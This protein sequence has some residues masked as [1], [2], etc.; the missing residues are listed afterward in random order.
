MT[1]NLPLARADTVRDGRGMQLATMLLLPAHLLRR[2]HQL[3]TAIFAEELQKED[4]T[5]IQYATMVAVA[6]LGKTDSTTIS[7]RIGIDRAT[8]GGVVDR[9]ERKGLLSRTPSSTD[10]RVKMLS[11]T[12]DGHAL[13]EAIEPAVMNVQKLL[14]RNLT[15]EESEQFRELLFK[16]VKGTDQSTEQPD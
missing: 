14:T 2:A 5:A 13:L 7:R 3:S 11:V 1:D 9:L 10:R 16:I 4:L 12:E 6:D 15:A 8:L